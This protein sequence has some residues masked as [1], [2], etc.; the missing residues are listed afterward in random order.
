MDWKKLRELIV[1]FPFK[2]FVLVMDDGRQFPITQPSDMGIQPGGERVLVA[3]E[4]EKVVF[5]RTA[6]VKEAVVSRS[7][8]SA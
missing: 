5:L 3:T 6:S 4:G 8:A 7:A 1:A 2:P